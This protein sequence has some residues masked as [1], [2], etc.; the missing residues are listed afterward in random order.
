MSY[1]QKNCLETERILIDQMAGILRLFL[2]KTSEE[3]LLKGITKVV[4]KAIALKNNMME[5]Q[6]LYDCYWIKGGQN[7]DPNI[8]DLAG[9]E[10]NEP[11]ALCTFPGLA[12][13]IVDQGKKVAIHVVKASVVMESTII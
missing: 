6:A 9:H 5:E 4:T 12:R 8:M 2:P 11:I 1:V 13:I 3:D 10:D 7:F